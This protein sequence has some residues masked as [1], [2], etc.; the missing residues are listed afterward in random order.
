M[1]IVVLFFIVATYSVQLYSQENK[2]T[3]KQCIETGI[4]NNIRVKQSGLQ[5][6]AAAINS[7]QA[8]SDMLPNLNGSFGYG[9]NKG[10]NVDP[11][12][13]SYINQQLTSSNI[14]LSSGVVLFNG[15]RL[16]NLI[17]QNN[18]TYE[19]TKMDLQQSKDN[20]TL[21]IILAYMQ[22]LSNE[23]ILV[24]S[25]GQADVT[26]KQV[27]RMDVMVKE[28]AAGNYL[29]AD[30][31]GQ[32][33]TEEISIINSANA[34]EQAKLNLCQLMNIDYNSKLQLE[35]DEASLSIT[36]YAA[37]SSDIY[38][39]ALQQFALIRANELRVKSAEKA[40]KLSRSGFYP[41]ISLNGNL[42]SSY[43]SLAETLTP[44]TTN[45]VQTGSY[46][47]INGTHNPVLKQE[48]NYSS[49]K[50]A[51]TKQLNNNIGTYFGVN[52]QIPLFNS[53]QSRNQV[54]LADLSLKNTVL[55]SEN[56][57]TQVKREIE[58]AHLNMTSSYNRYKILTEQVRDFEE[59]FRAAE[60]RF[61]NG[62]INSA[63]YLI[64]KNNLDRTKINL[65]QARYEYVFRTRLLDYFQGVLKI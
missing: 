6:E 19:A 30:L 50:T 52:M 54:K 17:K 46:V 21:N 34:V 33:A 65:T 1:R 58:Q 18:L 28:G 42:F 14:G 40:L 55:E 36:N 35:R 11:L 39:T 31:K 9:L 3:L 26:K 20:L 12:T 32:L 56:S 25:K 37:S 8:R 48:Q 2:M 63:E 10:R 43:S 44:T 59:S 41:T 64:S 16:Q 24:I 61:E 27:E 60:V 51:Y 57:K 38:N 5:T 15:M 22:V 7:Q 13:N 47:I 49:T 45:E 23:D 4:N 62:V 29:L 53:F